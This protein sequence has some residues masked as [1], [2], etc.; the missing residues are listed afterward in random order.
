M[1]VLLVGRHDDTCNSESK[2]ALKEGRLEAGR[3]ERMLQGRKDRDQEK[4]GRRRRPPPN[5]HPG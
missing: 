2:L 1:V 5:P 3:T 4:R